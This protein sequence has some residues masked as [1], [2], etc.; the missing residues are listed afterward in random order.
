VKNQDDVGA[1]QEREFSGDR[2]VLVPITSKKL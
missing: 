2:V 1:D